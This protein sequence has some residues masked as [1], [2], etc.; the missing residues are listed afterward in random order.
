MVNFGPWNG[1][2]VL[3]SLFDCFVARSVR[4][5]SK[6]PRAFESFGRV[7]DQPFP[8]RIFNLRGNGSVTRANA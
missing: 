2:L 3:D 5:G 6:R 7:R 8:E 4:P 1:E